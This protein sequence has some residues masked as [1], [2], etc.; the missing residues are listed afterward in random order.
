M[1]SILALRL[2]INRL[3]HV[4]C[5]VKSKCQFGHS[6]VSHVTVPR[7]QDTK[8]VRAST[9]GRPMKFQ[10]V[11]CCFAIENVRIWKTGCNN[12]LILFANFKA[13][14]F[15]NHLSYWYF[16]PRPEQNQDLIISAQK[17][18]TRVWR[19]TFKTAKSL[20]ICKTPTSRE[21]YCTSVW[22]ALGFNLSSNLPITNQN[23][24][25]NE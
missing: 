7:R 8:Y 24:W 13:I 3:S 23:L 9:V 20:T 14:I 15:L 10:L 16:K 6:E 21:W 5:T 12:G 22:R 18:Q 1:L 19:L 17:H 11:V 4:I 25:S 2:H